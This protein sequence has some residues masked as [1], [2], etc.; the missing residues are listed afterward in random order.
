MTIMKRNLLLL[1]TALT[2]GLAAQANSVDVTTQYITNPGFESCPAV[3][4]ESDGSVYLMSSWKS[5]STHSAYDY[6]DYGWKLTE[7]DKQYANGGVIAY[8][9]EKLRYSNKWVSVNGPAASPSGATTG[10]ALIFTGNTSVAYQQTESVTLPAGTYIFTVNVFAYNG[11]TSNP[12]PTIKLD[13]NNT[14][15]FIAENGTVYKSEKLTFTSNQWDTDVIKIEL[16]EDTKGVFQLGYGT[17]Y[18]VAVD[19]IKLEYDSSIIT[20]ELKTAITQAQA[21][22]TELGGNDA[23]LTAA[24]QQAVAYEANPTSAEGVHVEAEALY[25]AMGNAMKATTKAVNL[26]SVFMK[27]V[28]FETGDSKPWS[29]T[30]SVATP[31][32]ETYNMDGSYCMDFK[33]L[34]DAF[35]A[36]QTLSHLPQG[37]YMVD[38]LLRMTATLVVGEQTTKCNGSSYNNWFHRVHSSVLQ[39]EGGTMT[40]GAEGDR[41]TFIDNIRLFYATSQDALLKA[42]Y[43]QA[44]ADGQYFL[45]HADFAAVTGSERDDLM[46]KTEAIDTNSADQ[47]VAVT[48]MKTAIGVFVSALEDYKKFETEKQNAAAYTRAAYPYGSEDIFN[49]IQQVIATKATSADNA[50][51]LAETLKSLCFQYYVSNAYAE[52]MDGRVDYTSTV[53][54]AN[55]SGTSVN[56]AWATQNMTIRTSADTN[57]KRNAWTNPKTN[58]SDGTFYGVTYDYYRSG[59]G[60]TAYMRQSLSGLPEGSYLLAVTYLGAIGNLVDVKIDDQVI[61]QLNGV[62]MASSGKYGAGWIDF[63]FPFEKTSDEATD[64]LLSIESTYTSNYKDWCFDNVRLFKVSG[65]GAG[66]EKCATPNIVFEDGKLKFSCDTEGVQ[67]FATVQAT[68]AKDYQGSEIAI[69]GTY[70]VTVYA[71][72][73]GMADS[74]PA[75][76][77]FTAG[78]GEP[79]DTNK[80]GVVNVA[81]ITTIINKMAN[82]E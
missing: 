10:K 77:E 36:K 45:N 15:G 7:Q 68:D 33:N 66:E 17:Q 71:A 14:V 21:L 20:T 48:R 8:G 28:S 11:A 82:N 60:Q 26:S 62:G 40:V 22:S 44:K 18:Y 76:F 79:C 24:I 56:T 46:A 16:F 9:T 54:G 73:E 61:G 25:T 72:K 41:N 59:S 3:E 12:T 23:T 38:A 2:F 42:F 52:G 34:P 39:S 43:A 67:F 55:A 13:E 32:I 35:Y 81:D 57:I 4:A 74:D 50:K 78:G 37:Y 51:T 19:D 58:E 53:I 64:V 49:N 75:T 63:V 1:A 47:D 80:D 30:G 29:T 69:G 27:N 65:S 31:D 70:T 5:N 6:S